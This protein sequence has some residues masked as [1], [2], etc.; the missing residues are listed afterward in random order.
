M[1]NFKNPAAAP[2]N[3]PWAPKPVADQQAFGPVSYAPGWN[4]NSGKFPSKV[5][6]EFG[7]GDITKGEGGDLTQTGTDYLLD[8]VQNGI[9]EDRL[10]QMLE[11]TELAYNTAGSQARGLTYGSGGGESGVAKMSRGNIEMARGAG[12]A[13]DIREFEQYRNQTILQTIQSWLDDYNNAYA[14]KQGA[15]AGPW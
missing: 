1:N 10:R 15:A 7:L 6:A 4:P 14:I 9:P 13:R 11:N 5:E 8:I 3:S 12:K 2:P